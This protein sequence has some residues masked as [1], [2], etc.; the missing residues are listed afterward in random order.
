MYVVG[1]NKLG[2]YWRE[3]PEAE[4]EL[5]ALH[6]L[7]SAIEPAALADSLGAIARFDGPAAEL[8]LRSATVRI[9]INAAAGVALYVDIMPGEKLE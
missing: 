4:G 9:E 1:A 7:L 6:S 2:A 3:H 5:R 8:K